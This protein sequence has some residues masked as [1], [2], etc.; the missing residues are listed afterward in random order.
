MT[1]GGEKQLRL[2]GK[3]CGKEGPSGARRMSQ[4]P[5]TDR[6]GVPRACEP[7]AGGTPGPAPSSC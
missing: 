3:A 6:E 7:E 4:E 5:C 2:K 1:G